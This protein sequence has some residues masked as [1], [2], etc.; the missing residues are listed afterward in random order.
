M[1]KKSK[2]FLL[3]LL[4]ALLVVMA[5]SLVACGKK[6]SGKPGAVKVDTLK[7]D[8]YKITWS[9]SKNADKYKL[10]ITVG[11]GNPQEKTSY[12]T[13]YNYPAA[14]IMGDA[15]TINVS[16]R[17][18]NDEGDESK[19]VSKTFTKLQTIETSSLVFDAEGMMT[20]SG[21]NNAQSYDVNIN[22]TDHN[23]ANPVYTDFIYGQRNT[24][25]VRAKGPDDTFFAL[26]PTNAVT[27]HYLG[28]PTNVD[29]DGANLTW[30]G[31]A[32]NGTGFGVYINGNIYQDNVGD[33]KMLYDSA[34]NDFTAQVRALGNG[35]D[36]FPSKLSA[37]QE[38]I[39][40]GSVDNIMI[41]EKGMLIWDPIE[42]ATSYQLQLTD[43][44]STNITPVAV[45]PEYSIPEGLQYSV[46]IKPAT[47]DTTPNRKYFSVW[48]DAVNVGLLKA[49]TLEWNEEFALTDGNAAQA[50][51]WNTVNGDVKSYNIQIKFKPND[52][53]VE[54]VSNVPAPPAT[55]GLTYAYTGVGTY[56]IS[57]QSIAP[58]GS[59]WSNSRYSTE[60]QIIRIAAPSADITNFISSNAKDVTK[61][62]EVRY[63]NVGF[64]RGYALLSDGGTKTVHSV[65]Q[66]TYVLKANQIIT[67]TVT[68]E[69][70]LHYKVVA[71]GGIDSS[72]KTVILGTLIDDAL[73]VDIK[74]LATPTNIQLDGWNATWDQV[75]SASSYAVSA[76]GLYDASTTTWS[77]KNITTVGNSLLKIC[78]AGN[79][80][81]ILPSNYSET[82]NVKKLDA[83]Q[84]IRIETGE[85]EGKL[86][87]DEIDGVSSYNV[88]VN[89]S[90]TPIDAGQLDNMNKY[91]VD[92]GVLVVVEA[93]ANRWDGANTTYLITSEKSQPK[94]FTRL[95]A[96][97]FPRPAF[98]DNSLV[99]N[100]PSNV[101]A[102]SNYT[103]V[104][105]Y[106]KQGAGWFKYNG[107]LDG[108]SMDFS[109][110]DP[111][112]YQLRVKAIGD[113]RNTINSEYSQETS[114]RKLSSP[115][116]TKTE[117]QY[118]WA[119]VSGA[120]KYQ[121]W[122]DNILKDTQD[123]ANGTSTY[124][125]TPDFDLVKTYTVKIIA[126]GD[127]GNTTIDS[128]PTVRTQQ[129]KRLTIPEFTVAYSNPDGFK[130]DAT[131]N[132][133][134]SDPVANAMGYVYTIDGVAA[135]S[136]ET[137]SLIY[138]YNATQS[139]TYT[140]KVRSLGGK[141][142]GDGYYYI[143]SLDAKV[144]SLK[145][146]STPSFTT[147]PLSQDGEITWQAVEGANDYDIIIEYND[148]TE[149][150]EKTIQGN[151]CTDAVET[152]VSSISSIKVR[153]KGNGTTTISSAWTTW[154]RA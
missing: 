143:D 70:N 67:D 34:K 7:Y 30:Q 137:T 112:S 121:V 87:W 57:V 152:N 47:N 115:T 99:W 91:I 134:V 1:V 58:E 106:N 21:V 60:L 140:I 82:K 119:S 118:S 49:P 16:I 19:A 45:K 62:F 11:N 37:V 122:V 73:A 123:H 8:G 74:V 26:W 69:T 125:Y 25:K 113:G 53:T 44:N 38:F 51:T 147:T 130:N 116:V 135:A 78:A 107:S 79:G 132:V 146:F 142:A 10:E 31:N 64:A 52:S 111:G 23:T 43:N 139:G 153:V 39:F 56:K 95:S 86:L 80:K 92:S 65:A 17:A 124:F 32:T 150:I 93:V 104:V 48:C 110:M 154:T 90:N 144:Q 24:I 22:G 133:K 76:D 138:Y 61:G 102:S 129:T 14:T 55:P 114:I 18:L 9:N 85:A 50:L 33:T 148:G 88:Y 20:W 127:G 29:Y 59:D 117:T 75:P 131:I 108:A 94:Q 27:K 103:Y 83:P 96:P 68:E 36:I 81:Q 54:T 41:N 42:K 141:F 12:S 151:M 136:E 6:D 98:K 145:I 15:E 5:V 97:V 63:T 71:T 84:N 66:G 128:T 109:E 126:V 77:L 105:E 149:T 3:L 28:T 40:L 35:I 4:S 89:N 100:A 72:T 101:G 120:S 46:K 2:R 13:T